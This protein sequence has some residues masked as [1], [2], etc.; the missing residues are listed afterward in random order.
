MDT[1][2]GSEAC[3]WEVEAVVSRAITSGSNNVLYILPAITHRGPY[4]DGACPRMLM[5]PRT[6]PNLPSP[7]KTF[8]PDHN[9]ETLSRRLLEKSPYITGDGD[10][11]VLVASV[12]PDAGHSVVLLPYNSECAKACAG[13]ML[14]PFFLQPDGCG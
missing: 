6:Y 3:R 8:F 14:Y 9:R 13:A 10:C 12:L 11:A 7:F 4:G 5:Q 2:C 1:K